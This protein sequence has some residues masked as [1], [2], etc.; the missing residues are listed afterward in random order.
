MT[1]P[2]QKNSDIE[3][4]DEGFDEGTPLNEVQ[5]NQLL[6]LDGEPEAPAAP[7]AEPTLEDTLAARAE[8]QDP[9]PAEFKPT[10][11]E[12]AAED[13]A[14]LLL[15][16]YKRDDEGIS[17]LEN[18]ARHFQSEADRSKNRATVLEA[19]LDSIKASE[20][21]RLAQ[22]IRRDPAALQRA[23]TALNSPQA[24]EVEKPDFI[25]MGEIHDP[26][27]PSGKWFNHLVESR[28]SRLVEPQVS[29][30]RA[31]T[32]QR[33]EAAELLRIHPELAEPAVREEFTGFVRRKQEAGAVL[34]LK[35]FYRLHLAERAVLPEINGAPG[36]NR[37][38][39]KTPRG[40]GGS[41][42]RSPQLTKAER[43]SVAILQA[44]THDDD[45]F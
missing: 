3:A 7:A 22:A 32:E 29:S 16:R 39:P 38:A 42:S 19:D 15:G 21:Y 2:R 41:P 31:E 6:A 20:E 44:G 36:G 34:P 5:V 28:A 9:T 1:D 35:D 17:N 25:D 13:D 26:G 40:T 11:K 18:H 27:T 43:E 37:E 8:P 23:Q 33:V 4:N 12:P 45:A 30:I 14:A 10:S 24:E